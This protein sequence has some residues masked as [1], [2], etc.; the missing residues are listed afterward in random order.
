MADM[1]ENCPPGDKNL[2]YTQ[3]GIIQRMNHLP[4]EWSGAATVAAAEITCSRR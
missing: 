3:T 2:N 4:V 1:E